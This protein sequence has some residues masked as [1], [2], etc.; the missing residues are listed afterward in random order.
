MC[1]RF[2]IIDDPLT[3]FLIEITGQSQA[4]RIVTDY[5][6][7]P[8]QTVPVLLYDDIAESWNLRKMRWWLTP[9]W[10]GGPSTRYS[11]F[12]AKSETLSRSRAFR[13]PFKKRRCIIPA[14][15]YYEWKREGVQKTPYCMTPA[16]DF[17]FAFA[18]LWD[19][20]QS[21]KQNLESCAIVTAQAPLGMQ[22]I[23]NRMPV[24]LT[25][26]DA[27][28]WARGETH[29]NELEAILRPEIRKGIRVTPVSTLVNNAR[30]K[31][32]RCVEPVGES[33]TV[34]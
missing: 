33:F 10:S 22:K 28:A 31:D 23:H 14:S 6:I 20:W 24:L 29:L 27:M 3:Q 16:E 8:T 12:N 1:G 7:V 15:G 17:G 34:N 30:N 2:N 19:C 13:E 4:W 25:D 26:Y 18:G 32:A 21:E 5:N 11:M 9:S